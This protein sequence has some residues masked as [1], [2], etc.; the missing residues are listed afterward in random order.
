MVKIGIHFEFDPEMPLDQLYDFL[1]GRTLHFK[2]PPLP[3]LL[4]SCQ[5]IAHSLIMSAVCNCIGF[6]IVARGCDVEI[7]SPLM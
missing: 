3:H 4:L 2:Q 1:T 7:N 6:Y 5:L